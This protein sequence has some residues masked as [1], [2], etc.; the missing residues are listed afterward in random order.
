MKANLQFYRLPVGFLSEK[1]FGLLEVIVSL[2][3]QVAVGFYSK[4]VVCWMQLSLLNGYF[5]VSF[6]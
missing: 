2:I 3:I 1:L 6:R 5:I 4:K